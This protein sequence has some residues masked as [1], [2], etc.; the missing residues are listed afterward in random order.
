MARQRGNIA[1][2]G[3]SAVRECPEWRGKQPVRFVG[4][5]PGK[6][7]LTGIPDASVFCIAAALGFLP[8]LA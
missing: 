2:E 4:G 5:A 6:R 7:P 1:A 8:F 3:I